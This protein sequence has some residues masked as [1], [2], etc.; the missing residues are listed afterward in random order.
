M[1]KI[2]LF[3]SL[4]FS[5]LFTAFRKNI[6]WNQTNDLTVWKKHSI[7]ENWKLGV[8]QGNRADKFHLLYLHLST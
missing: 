3:V 4:F 2:I 6:C 1:Y 8:P 7:W 5:S